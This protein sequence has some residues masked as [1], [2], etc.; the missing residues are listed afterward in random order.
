[1]YEYYLIRYSNLSP[2]IQEAVNEQISINIYRK[3]DYVWIKK[4]NLSI[5]RMYRKPAER[6]IWIAEER[7]KNLLIEIYL[8]E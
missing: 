2:E 7:L 3:G 6:F 4:A 5:K 1:M 8:G